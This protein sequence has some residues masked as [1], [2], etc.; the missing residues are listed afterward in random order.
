MVGDSLIRLISVEMVAGGLG[1][2]QQF[3]YLNVVAIICLV[4]HKL[5][6]VTSTKVLEELPPHLIIHSQHFICHQNHYIFCDVN[7]LKERRSYC[8]CVGRAVLSHIF[9]LVFIDLIFQLFI[10]RNYH[11]VF[12]FIIVVQPHPGQ[13]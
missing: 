11:H 7:L 8:N 13:Q 10:Q 4:A 9:L 2:G 1:Y 12:S 6:Q 5:H 3:C